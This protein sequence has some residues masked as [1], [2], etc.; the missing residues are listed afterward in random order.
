[1]FSD[2]KYNSSV[3]YYKKM[4]FAVYCDT[5]KWEGWCVFTLKTEKQIVKQISKDHWN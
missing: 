3:I 4:L 2:I 5:Y 1:M